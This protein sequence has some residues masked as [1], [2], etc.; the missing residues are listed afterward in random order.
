MLASAKGAIPSLCRA[1]S[2]C[3]VEGASCSVTALAVRWEI[4]RFRVLS[5]ATEIKALCHANSCGPMW[6][7]GKR[8][9]M[10]GLNLHHIGIAV[11]DVDSARRALRAS[12]RLRDP[13][14]HNPRPHPDRACAALVASRRH[15]LPR[16]GRAGRP[17]Q[18][19][20]RSRRQRRRSPSPLLRNRSHRRN[21]PRLRHQGLVP[22]CETCRRHRLSR[23]PE[24]PGSMGADRIPIELVERGAPGPTLDRHRF[25]YAYV[26]IAFP[27]PGRFKLPKALALHARIG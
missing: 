14:T 6:L 9:I 22:L 13:H 5:I 1:F 8:S 17:R 26:P 18:Q 20:F 2:N 4:D 21:L 15:Q 12:L 10:H 27:V 25:W 3:I 7:G 23:T 24:S 11:A 19:T 16:T